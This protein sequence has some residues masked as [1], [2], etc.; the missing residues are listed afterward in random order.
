MGRAAEGEG[1]GALPFVLIVT[2]A[3]LFVAAMGMQAGLSG[4]RASVQ[5]LHGRNA[6]LCAEAGLEIA[7]SLLKD[8]AVWNSM[9]SYTFTGG[10]AQPANYPITGS[11]EGLADYTY[12]A[13]IR[14]N[15]DEKFPADNNPRADTDGTV[16]VDSEARQGGLSV[17]MVSALIQLNDKS[18]FSDYSHQD[19]LGALKTGNQ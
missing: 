10:G 1:G 14:D 7:R 17:A 16:I 4:R 19:R 18:V 9:L 6:Q 2:T 3:L 11:C 12:Y 8:R 15:V 5:A 13:T